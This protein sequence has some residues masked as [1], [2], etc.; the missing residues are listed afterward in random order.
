[1]RALITGGRGFVGPYLK[2][3][4]E[5][6]DFEVI[7]TDIG[8]LKNFPDIK[9]LDVLDRRAM[10]AFFKGDYFDHIYHLAGFSS[11][12]KSYE[13]PEHCYDLNV[14]GTKNLLDAIVA[15]NKKPKILIVSSAHVCFE[16][17]SPY[18]K[19]RIEQEKLTPN[20]DLPIIISRSFNHTGPGRQPEFSCSSYAKQIAEIEK[21]LQEPIIY[22]GNLEAKRDFTDVRDVVKAYYL[23]LKKIAPQDIEI[24]NICSGKSYKMKDILNMLLELSN[25]EI[26]IRPDPERM[27]PSDIPEL[28]GNYIKFHK[29]TG[30][31][32]EIKFKQTLKDILDY[33]REKINENYPIQTSKK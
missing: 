5:T 6:Q 18:A 17:K 15:S 1:M 24:Y 13:Q 31:K 23:A 27:R 30:W 4:L 8:N 33:W 7:A 19:S 11:P 26:E 3:Y 2:N 29:K 22:V 21:G 12:G 25:V 32:P 16:A 28:C 14:N 10:F 9:Y 20:Y